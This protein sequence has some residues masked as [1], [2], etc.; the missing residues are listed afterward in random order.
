MTNPYRPP[1]E[2][3]ADHHGRGFSLLDWLRR[4]WLDVVDFVMGEPMSKP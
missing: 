4:L 3:S 2:E 1:R